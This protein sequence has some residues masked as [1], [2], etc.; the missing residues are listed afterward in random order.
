MII[1]Y[2][3]FFY[4]GLNTETCQLALESRH[5]CWLDVNHKLHFQSWSAVLLGRESTVE[6]NINV[7]PLLEKISLESMFH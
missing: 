1:S 7:L 3:I 2:G 5:I 6:V 4:L